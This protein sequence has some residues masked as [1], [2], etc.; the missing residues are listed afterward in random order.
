MTYKFVLQHSS[1][2]LLLFIFLT[3]IVASLDGIVLSSVISGVTKFTNESNFQEVISF[4]VFSLITYTIVMFSGQINTILKNKLICQLN[5]YI[6]NIY[7][8][9]QL[10]SDSPLSETD[11]ILSFLLN[12]Y[13]GTS[14]NFK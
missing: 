10:I 4:A 6:K 1:K 9:K 7:I 2:L 11:E 3:M 13:K 5:M 14:K 12:D 8:K